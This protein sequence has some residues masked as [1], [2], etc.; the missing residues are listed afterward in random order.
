[1]LCGVTREDQIGSPIPV[2]KISARD[3]HQSILSTT[4]DD[5]AVTDASFD[6]IISIST[7]N[8][9][10]LRAGMD[11]RVSQLAADRVID[12]AAIQF[13]AVLPA[14]EHVE[15]G[16]GANCVGSTATGAQRFRVSLA[17]N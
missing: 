5:R 13:A 8:Q 1:M 11:G 7:D 6:Q 4:C 10:S 3:A 14:A 17:C 15:A 9:A 2:K 12:V 16:I